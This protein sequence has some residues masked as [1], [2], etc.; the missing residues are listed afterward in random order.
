MG[1]CDNL[2]LYPFSI[3]PESLECR[4]WIETAPAPNPGPT[5]GWGHRVLAEGLSD[6]H[7]W[8]ELGPPEFLFLVS[9]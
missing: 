3:L 4:L 8:A 2:C 5:R 7:S 9:C 6:G 1:D